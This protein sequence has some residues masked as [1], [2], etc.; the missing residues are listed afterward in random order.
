MFLAA[1]KFVSAVR[2]KLCES[3]AAIDKVRT[4]VGNYRAMRLRELLAEKEK[5]L[6][7]ERAKAAESER[8]RAKSEEIKQQQAMLAARREAEERAAILELLQSRLRQRQHHQQQQQQRVEPAPAQQQQPQSVIAGLLSKMQQQQQQQHQPPTAPSTP[9]G[10]PRPSFQDAPSIHDLSPVELAAAINA[11]TK[12]QNS[13]AALASPR[14]QPMPMPLYRAPPPNAAADAMTN[15]SFDRERMTALLAAICASK[16]GFSPHAHTQQGGVAPPPQQSPLSPSQHWPSAINQLAAGAHAQALQ[17]QQ[18]QQH[19]QLAAARAAAAS[20]SMSNMP[21]V[22]A[23]AGSMPGA[24]VGSVPSN[25]QR[26]LATF[27]AYGS[28]LSGMMST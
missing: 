5:Q 2:V 23:M 19:R 10:L 26:S 15:V 6:A 13:H 17:Q 16:S 4:A 22:S 18:Q 8:L 11:A 28:A 3:E 20:S 1:K 9:R 21:G 14:D 7:V 25:Y 24:K 12:I 27:G